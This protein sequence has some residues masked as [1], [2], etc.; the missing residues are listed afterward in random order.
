MQ[1]PL[2]FVVKKLGLTD[3]PPIKAVMFQNAFKAINQGAQNELEVIQ[4]DR[5]MGEQIGMK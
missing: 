3:I 1:Q 5:F 2:K 4:K